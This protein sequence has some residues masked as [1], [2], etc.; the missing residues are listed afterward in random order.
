MVRLAFHFWL[1]L[2]ICDPAIRSLVDSVPW[3]D[4][5]NGSPQQKV[6]LLCVDLHALHALV[7]PLL[8]SHAA[9]PRRSLVR[10]DSAGTDSLCNRTDRIVRRTVL[11]HCTRQT[12]G[13]FAGSTT[14]RGVEL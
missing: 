8:A 5:S 11:F 14:R 12:F 13:S 9:V 2:G 3:L 4:G 1:G 6:P 10:C 7:G